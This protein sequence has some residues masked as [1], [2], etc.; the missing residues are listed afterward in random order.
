MELATNIWI[1]QGMPQNGRWQIEKRE[2]LLMCRT[3]EA[4][5]IMYPFYIRNEKSIILPL[6]EAQIL[7]R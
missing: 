4:V 1:A 7:A 6:R 2:F 3:V 5:H